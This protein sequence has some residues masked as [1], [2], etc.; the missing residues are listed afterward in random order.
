MFANIKVGT[1]INLGF[2]SVLALLL[3]VAGLGFFGLRSAS[4]AFERYATIAHNTERVATIER[5]VV[6][7]RRNLLAY[8]ASGDDRIAAKVRDM[9]AGIRRQLGELQTAMLD[10][11]RKAKAER[12]GPVVGEYASDFET[13]VHL[14]A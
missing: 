2:A 12:I 5:D 4:D 9:A 11:G 13:L 10:P 8:V 7:M 14:R 3:L 1:R 6:E